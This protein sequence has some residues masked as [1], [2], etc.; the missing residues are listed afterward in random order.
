MR[1][2]SPLTPS[3]GERLVRLGTSLLFGEAAA[4]LAHFTGVKV[5][6]E[7]VRRLTEAAGA[8]RV[9]I[10]TELVALLERTLPDE[11]CGPAVLLMSVDGTK[12]SLVG[13][14][15]GEVKTVA[16]GALTAGAAGPY[17]AALSSFSRLTDAATFAR[18]ATIETHR[19]GT[20]GAGTVS[21][22]SPTGRAVRATWIYTTR[23]RCGCWLSPTPS[24]TSEQSPNAGSVRA[25]PPEASVWGGQEHRL[26]HGE[27]AAVVTALAERA[28][29]ER[30]P[31]VRAVLEGCATIWQCADHLH[32]QVFV[33]AGRP[34]GSG[35]VEGALRRVVEARLRGRAFI[36]RGPMS[37]PV[38]AVRA[39]GEPALGRGAAP[40]LA[41]PERDAA[42]IAYLYSSPSPNAHRGRRPTAVPAAPRAKT[43]VNG[44]PT[45]NHR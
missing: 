29:T 34:I 25:R 24:N 32:N 20:S 37:L 10:E 15:W 4:L 14:E 41:I 7:T 28:A 31:D 18:L 16:S 33:A 42:P 6:A 40:A 27:E 35:C 12:A 2:S 19:C 13:G 11:P 39:G 3:L 21:W 44:K 45:A 38:G 43:I 22:R 30:R 5:G 9:A 36:G 8:T 26:R 1:S 17:T 23:T